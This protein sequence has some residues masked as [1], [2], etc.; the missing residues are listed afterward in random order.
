MRVGWNEKTIA[1]MEAASAFTGF[2]R[3][4]AA[5][6]RPYLCL[7]GTLCDLGC[8]L[9]LI[10]LE[11]SPWLERVTCLDTSGPALAALER[12]ADRRGCTNLELRQGDVETLEGEWDTVL[13]VFF[14]FG[15]RIP[16]WLTHC[17]RG[18]VVVV[19]DGERPS[20]G[21][22]RPSKRYTAGYAQMLLD[23]AGISYQMERHALEYGQPFRSLEEAEE[24][25]R[26][27]SGGDRREDLRYLRGRLTAT[28]DP[29]YPW[30]LPQEKRFSIFSI[31]K[32]AEGVLKRG[33]I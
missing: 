16:R 9:G 26:I 4:L 6:I 2:H 14:G 12:L 15:D 28:G 23:Q 7:G 1:W 8:G 18:L 33:S 22:G 21:P 25:G 27:Y 29:D 11:I 3:K 24:F 32:G 13:G 20:F 5:L 17:R 10:D 31:Q 30:Y 19:A